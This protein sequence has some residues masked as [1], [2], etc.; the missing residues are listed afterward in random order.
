MQIEKE[1]ENL[2][3]PIVLHRIEKETRESLP[4]L[5]REKYG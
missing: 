2:I 3:M 4:N 1:L 5:Q